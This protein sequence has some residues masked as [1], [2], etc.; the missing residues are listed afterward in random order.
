MEK[1]K[2]EKRKGQ[3]KEYVGTKRKVKERNKIIQVSRHNL[4][5]LQEH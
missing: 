5:I 1:K 2:R 3:E 4:H